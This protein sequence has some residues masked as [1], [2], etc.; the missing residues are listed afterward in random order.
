[1]SSA[2][3]VYLI[4]GPS[5]SGLHEIAEE[6]ASVFDFDTRTLT[7]QRTPV[8]RKQALERFLRRCLGVRAPEDWQMAMVGP[9]NPATRAQAANLADKFDGYVKGTCQDFIYDPCQW[10]TAG[11]ID[12]YTALRAAEV[13]QA[14]EILRRRM[15]PQERERYDDATRD[16]IRARAHGE[17]W[18]D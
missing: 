15:S 10:Y 5:R 7:V 16:L 14:E 9:N 11:Q 18:A 3:H 6:L 8:A 17:G 12:R 1:M 2:F 4:Y 13:A